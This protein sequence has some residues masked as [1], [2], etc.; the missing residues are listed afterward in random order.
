MRTDEVTLKG[1]NASKSQ[2]V[3]HK[4]EQIESPTSEGVGLSMFSKSPQN[5]ETEIVKPQPKKEMIILQS[6]VYYNPYMQEP[7]KQSGEQNS[8]IED[9]KYA[10]VEFLD[11]INICKIEILTVFGHSQSYLIIFRRNFKWFLKTRET[12][13]WFKV[14]MQLL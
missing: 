3:L 2:P 7:Q 6:R 12:C 9:A 1:V 4:V 10:K 13:I 14:S 8:D 11:F 5:V